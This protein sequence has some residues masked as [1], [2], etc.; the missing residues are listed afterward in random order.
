MHHQHHHHHPPNPNNRAFMLGA[1]INIAFVII[2]VAYGLLA[3]SLAL[4]A[5]AGH[6]LSDVLILL[7]AWGANVLASRKATASHTYGYKRAT[8]LAAFFSG[9]SLFATM[10]WIAIEAV[11]RFD[12]ITTPDSVTIMLVASIGIGVNFFTAALFMRSQEDDLNVK[13]AFLHMMVDGLVSVAVVISGAV[14]YFTNWSLIDPLLSL[15]I[16]VAIGLSSWGLLRNSFDLAVDAVPP[17]IDLAG[18][19]QYLLA[20]D[21]VSAIHD[22]HIW[23]ISTTQVALSAHIVRDKVEIDDD[24]LEQL[25]TELKQQFQIDHSTI[26]IENGAC[27]Q[28]CQH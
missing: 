10:A 18:V 3:D 9:L 13:G 23:A 15:L 19:R 6:N 25:T 16:V 22:L 4:L 27:Q 5:D 14:I 7:V 12:T 26:Q 20:Q 28:N 24:F 11:Q 2:E 1:L 8:I 17:H 21:R